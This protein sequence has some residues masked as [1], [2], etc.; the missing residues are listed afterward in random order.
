M[1]VLDTNV[2]SE[3]MRAAPATKVREWL[4]LVQEELLVT[5]VITVAEIEYGIARLPESRRRRDIAKRFAD[6]TG[7]QF[8]FAVLPFDEPAAR[9][10]GQLRTE[11]ERQ[12]R[13]TQMADMI[14]AAITMAAGADL[15]TRNSKDFSGIG[16]T[17]HDP[18][19]TRS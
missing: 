1:I 9:L 12:G 15:A 2:I 18:W 5:T 14:I 17:V 11:R 19:T 13:Q 4:A 7:P 10:S 3:L 6:L 8:D 16:L